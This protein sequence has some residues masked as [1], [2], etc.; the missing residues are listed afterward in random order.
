M[1]CKAEIPP[2]KSDAS[3]GIGPKHVVTS[4]SGFNDWARLS[5]FSSYD[6]ENITL[7]C[8]DVALIFLLY[9]QQSA[10]DNGPSMRVGEV[11]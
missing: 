5:R 10:P 9:F 11:S 3:G 2:G 4:T 6:R 8:S 7:I 1:A